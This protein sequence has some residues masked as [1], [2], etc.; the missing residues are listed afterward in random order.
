MNA[1]LVTIAADRNSI[2]RLKADGKEQ[3]AT[4][5][6]NDSKHKDKPAHYAEFSLGTL[7]EEAKIK[8]IQVQRRLNKSNPD[9]YGISLDPKGNTLASLDPFRLPAFE[10]VTTIASIGYW[11]DATDTSFDITQFDL[12]PGTI[13]SVLNGRVQDLDAIVFKDTSS[14][15]DFVDQASFRDLPD[16]TGTIT[17]VSYDIFTPVGDST[18]HGGTM[19][20][21]LV[22]IGL[23]RHMRKTQQRSPPNS[24]E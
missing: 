23:L 2:V 6:A 9:W 19:A 18:I 20:F 11:I 15:L 14:L 21:L 3:S 22:S 4:T 5:V 17:I 13:L 16:F 12:V 24:I 1:G 10:T 8:E 7:A